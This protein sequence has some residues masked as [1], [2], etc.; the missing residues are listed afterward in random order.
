MGKKENHKNDL[1]QH[2]NNFLKNKDEKPIYKYIFENSDLPG[3]RANLEMAYAFGEYIS[4]I[5]NELYSLIWSLLEK[6]TEIS[7][8]KAPTNDPKEFLSFCGTVGLGSIT[9][10]NENHTAK[11]L[12]KLKILAIDSRWR[13]QEVVAMTLWRIAK[14]NSEKTLPSLRTWIKKDN[15]LE[16]RA[17]AAGL[18]DPDFLKRKK[19]TNGVQKIFRSI[20]KV[21]V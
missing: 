16:I 19:V 21:I 10:I 20:F 1:K 13:I 11:T 15:W 18:A 14:S 3:R 2:L 8:K 17:V 4:E 5:T 9:S 12:S 6:M 7:D